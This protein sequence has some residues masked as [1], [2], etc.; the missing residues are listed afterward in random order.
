VHAGGEL[1]IPISDA[2]GRGPR[3]ISLY[4]PIFKVALLSES[5]VKVPL[6]VFYSPVMWS[7]TG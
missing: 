4:R 2:F 6:L 1:L 5:E 7:E 3:A